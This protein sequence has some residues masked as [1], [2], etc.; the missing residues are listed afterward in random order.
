MI[1]HFPERNGPP[2]PEMTLLARKDPLVT[3]NDRASGRHDRT[4]VIARCQA[5]END[6]FL[7][8]LYTLRC[9]AVGNDRAVS[10]ALAPSDRK[11]PLQKN[12]YLSL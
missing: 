4:V 8:I 9:Q 2:G 7:L 6:S 3:G 11:R 1:T 12:C 10:I 5:V